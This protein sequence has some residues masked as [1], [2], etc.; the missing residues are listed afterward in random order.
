MIKKIDEEPNFLFNIVFSDEATFEVNDN[1]IDIIVEVKRTT[2]LDFD[3]RIKEQGH[4][5]VVYKMGTYYF[6][7]ENEYYGKFYVKTQLNLGQLI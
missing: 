5:N 2:R 1:E 6:N 7:P 4:F 3:H